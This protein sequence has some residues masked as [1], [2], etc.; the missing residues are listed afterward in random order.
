MSAALVIDQA[1]EPGPAG[2]ADPIRGVVAALR[3]NAMVLVVLKDSEDIPEILT[4]LRV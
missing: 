4:A 1:G 2:E 3:P